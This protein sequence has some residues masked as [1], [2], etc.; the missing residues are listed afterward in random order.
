M[1]IASKGL[2]IKVKVKV[3]VMGQASAV[4]PTSV[5][6]SFYSKKCEKQRSPAVDAVTTA[7]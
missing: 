1:T 7:E 6:G 4:G 5:E 3:K 2:K